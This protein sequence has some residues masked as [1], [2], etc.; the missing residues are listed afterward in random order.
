MTP[1]QKRFLDGPITPQ[2]VRLSLPVLVVLALQTFVG[3]AET[4]FQAIFGG[5]NA[6]GFANSRSWGRAPALRRLE[7]ATNLEKA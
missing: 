3:I 5:I 7:P 6:I 4:Y 2:L 1:Q